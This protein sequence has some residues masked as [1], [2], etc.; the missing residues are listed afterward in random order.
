MSYDSVMSKVSQSQALKA[1]DAEK[2]IYIFENAIRDVSPE[3]FGFFSEVIKAAHEAL[4]MED[5]YY[6]DELL[7]KLLSENWHILEEYD[8]RF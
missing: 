8:M 6:L 1:E 5:A 3:H 4:Q 2:I 7:P